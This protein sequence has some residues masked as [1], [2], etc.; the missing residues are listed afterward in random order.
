MVLVAPE[1]AEITSTDE[2]SSMLSELAAARPEFT[3]DW[4]HTL[5]SGPVQ[6]DAAVALAANWATFDQPATEA[7]ISTL[8]DGPVKEAAMK[9]FANPSD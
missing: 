1:E 3:A 6:T 5:P 7:W 2:L 8:T 9:A 4:L